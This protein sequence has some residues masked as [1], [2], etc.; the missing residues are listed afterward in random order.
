MIKKL[1]LS[2]LVAAMAWSGLAQAESDWPTRQVKV[3]VPYPPGGSAD[4]MG[5]LV[6]KKLTDATGST[7]IVENISGGATIPAATAVL[8]DKN[9]GHTL[10]MASDNTLNINEHLFEKVP[11]ASDDFVPIT[12]LNTYPHWLIVKNEGQF[13]NFEDFK[14][15]IIQ[16]PGAVSIS[17]NTIGGAAYL[18]LVKWR[19]ANKLDFEII[20]YRGSP[21]AVQDLVGGVTH[22]HL[23]VVGSSIS[24]AR[25]KAVLPVAVLQDT[26]LAEFPTA[27]TQQFD[28]DTDLVVRANLSVVVK[29][30]TPDELIEHI[31][32]ILKKGS[33]DTD[34]QET[35]NT[36]AYEAVLTEPAE[37]QAFVKN[38]SERYRALVELSGLEKQ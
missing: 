2:L 25:N 18:A 24:H 35:L 29:K 32:D 15:Y 1:S 7:A 6:A 27:V 20:P 37:A 14:Q 4:L 13:S 33:N 5:R 31:Y 8:R 26:P 23:D 11:Y 10:F 3:V 16:N 12:V 36:L 9:D 30:G 17:V 38:E 21:P 22:A 19:H 28:K 34:F